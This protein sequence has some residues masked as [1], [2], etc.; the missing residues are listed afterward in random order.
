MWSWG[1]RDRRTQ[2]ANLVCTVEH[3]ERQALTPEVVLTSTHV[4]E[5]MHVYTHKDYFKNQVNKGAV[6]EK[7]SQF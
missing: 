4:H 5:R 1:G 6:I 7:R 2:P 3:S